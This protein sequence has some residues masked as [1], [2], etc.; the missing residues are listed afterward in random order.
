M[1]VV[2]KALLNA[3]NDWFYELRGKYL[4]Q[5]SRPTDFFV[6]DPRTDGFLLVGSPVPVLVILASYYYFVTDFGPKFMEKRPPFDLKRVI[7]VYNL[8]QILAN[9]YIVLQVSYSL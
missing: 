3:Y 2:L 6:I 9:L 7:I 5:F 8:V 4:L 1:A